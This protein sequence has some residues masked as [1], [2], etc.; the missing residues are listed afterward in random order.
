PLYVSL[1]F[2]QGPVF[3]VNSR[4]GRFSASCSAQEPLLPKVRGQFAEFLNEGSL[5]RLR[6]S[7][8]PTCVGLRYGHRSAP[9]QLFWSGPRVVLVYGFPAT[10]PS[11]QISRPFPWT[12]QLQRSAP[13]AFPR[14]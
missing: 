10:S 3:L 4:L 8:P 12:E 14:P 5:V 1:R 2:G 13:P 11:G 6:G 7:P 9:R